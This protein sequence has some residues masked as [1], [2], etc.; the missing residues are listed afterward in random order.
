MEEQTQERAE[1]LAD[2]TPKKKRRQ[3]K[4]MAKKIKTP[5]EPGKK[6]TETLAFKFERALAC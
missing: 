6:L 5:R 1:E 2:N 3:L 4:N